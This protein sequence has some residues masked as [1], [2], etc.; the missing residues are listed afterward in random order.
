M[1]KV[2]EN[3]INGAN[4]KSFLSKSKIIIQLSSMDDLV[5]LNELKEYFPEHS[6]LEISYGP[7]IK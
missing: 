7:T 5:K 2:F 1:S 6:E 4:F 3:E